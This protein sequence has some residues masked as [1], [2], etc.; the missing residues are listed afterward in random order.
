MPAACVCSSGCRLSKEKTIS[1][2]CLPEV[3]LLVWFNSWPSGCQSWTVWNLSAKVPV[4]LHLFFSRNRPILWRCMFQRWN[5]V[6]MHSNCLVYR[7]IPC[8]Y[9]TEAYVKYQTMRTRRQRNQFNTI[10]SSPAVIGWQTWALTSW[11]AP[12]RS[13]WESMPRHPVCLLNIHHLLWL[14]K[15]WSRWGYAIVTESF[16]CLLYQISHV[17]N[18]IKRS[19]IY[20][21]IATSSSEEEFLFSK[22]AQGLQ[23]SEFRGNLA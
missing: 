10:I 9:L 21:Y 12:S 4:C 18:E 16:C 3:V 1:C 8:C 2:C 13:S 23:N 11:R 22:T 5:S 6:C 14:W 7:Q 20:I 19:Y 17:P 15:R